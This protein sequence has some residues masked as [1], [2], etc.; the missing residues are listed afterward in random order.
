MSRPLLIALVCI[1]A[2]CFMTDTHASGDVLEVQATYRWAGLSP[3]WPHHTFSITCSSS[4]ECAVKAV[5]REGQPPLTD[6]KRCE[7]T[8][9]T[10]VPRKLVEVLPDAA[11]ADLKAVFKPVEMIGHTDDYPRWDVQI[12]LSSGGIRLLN[13]SNTGPKG[14]WNVQQSGRWSVQQSDR[15]DRAFKAAL[16]P[17][18]KSVKGAC[19]AR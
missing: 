3:T 15:F 11:R 18:L 7:R 17:I 9:E 1:G 10:S 5:L 14:T 2:F 13:T 12:R 16:E 19:P 4:P 8:V 6:P